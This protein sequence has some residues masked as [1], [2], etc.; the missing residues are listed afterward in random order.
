V[1]APLELDCSVL[2]EEGA[3]RGG[4]V[5]WA[6][7][8]GGEAKKRTN[9]RWPPSLLTSDPASAGGVVAMALGLFVLLFFPPASGS[10]DARIALRFFFTSPGRNL[11]SP[12]EFVLRILVL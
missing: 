12:V 6:H 8:G 11:F 9:E 4:L 3:G 1:R 7:G 10:R 2:V 5:S